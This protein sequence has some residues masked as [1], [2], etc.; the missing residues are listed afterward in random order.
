TGKR[1]TRIDP[2][3]GERKVAGTIPDVSAPGAQDGL[4]GMALHPDLLRGRNAD[5]V[6][7]YYTYV[8]QAKGPHVKFSDPGSPYRYLYGKVAR[9]TYNQA[10]GTL[11]GRVDLI[12]GLPV[13]NDHVSGRLK[14]G[15]DRKLYLTVGEQ[16]NN[17]L[18]NYCFPIE[19]QRLPSPEEL[20]SKNYA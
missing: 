19:A 10:S 4:L 6:Y 18:G 3:T 2:T 15:P 11:S 8:D 9:L 17:Q 16:G 13:G 7:V 1:I 14:I 12:T 5:Y 20:N